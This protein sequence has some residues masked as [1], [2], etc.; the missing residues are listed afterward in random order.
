MRG[1]GGYFN[2][3]N[4]VSLDIENL[5]NLSIS[6]LDKLELLSLICV[7]MLC[8]IILYTS[9]VITASFTGRS[10]S[11]VFPFKSLTALALSFKSLSRMSSH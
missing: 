5:T 7:I 3:L 6:D 1:K 4:P 10:C 11:L 9:G 8:L 2:N